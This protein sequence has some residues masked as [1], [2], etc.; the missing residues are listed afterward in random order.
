MSSHPSYPPIHLD[1]LTPA[2]RNAIRDELRQCLA[3]N[4]DTYSNIYRYDDL[5]NGEGHCWGLVDVDDGTGAWRN[6]GRKFRLCFSAEHR[7][8]GLDCVRGRF[9]TRPF[10]RDLFDTLGLNAM[11]ALYDA[12]GTPWSQTPPLPNSDTLCTQFLWKQ[13]ESPTLQTLQKVFNRLLGEDMQ[14]EVDDHMD[15]DDRDDL[16]R[17]HDQTDGRVSDVE[18][19][20]VEEEQKDLDIDWEKEN[21]VEVHDPDDE[22]DSTRRGKH[23]LGSFDLLF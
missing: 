11:R 1:H 10:R 21:W 3:R 16:N 15:W 14:E 9:I 8:F 2:E 20:S 17:L 18:V 13:R 19:P 4:I 7:V 23:Y 22:A 6:A 5:P 12:L